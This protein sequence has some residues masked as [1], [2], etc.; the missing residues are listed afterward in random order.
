VM[1]KKKAKI[2]LGQSCLAKKGKF[3]TTKPV[4]RREGPSGWQDQTKQRQQK[5]GS[6]GGAAGE[7]FLPSVVQVFQQHMC[8]AE[9]LLQGARPT[10]KF[11]L[12]KTS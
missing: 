2:R 5:G 9:K 10:S 1:A 8:P 11:H 3:Q 6:K 4:F 12:A 7:K